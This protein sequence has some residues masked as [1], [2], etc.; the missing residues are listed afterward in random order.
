[1]RVRTL[2]LLTVLLTLLAV[3]ISAAATTRFPGMRPFNLTVPP[4]YNRAIPEPLIIAL[5]GY[6]Q[7]GSDLE[8]YLKLESLTRST[9]I[10]YAYPDGT[11]DSRGVWFRNG[12]PECC[13]FEYPKVNDDA[14][15]MSIIDKVSTEYAVDPQRIF[16][17]GHSNGGLT[18]R[19][20]ALSSLLILTLK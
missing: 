2:I 12:T 13:D 8:R 15:I 9:G 18:G 11:K 1:M 17:I 16:I 6:N 3:E 14:Y 19:V 10:L 7:T 5:S 4:S 20:T